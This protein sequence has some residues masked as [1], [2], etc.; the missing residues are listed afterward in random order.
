MTFII[1]ILLVDKRPF[2]TVLRDLNEL[3]KITYQKI[4]KILIW[5]SS[6]RTKGIQKSVL[7]GLGD[8][9]EEFK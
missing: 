3:D 2:I 9:I 7:A 6:V 5:G 8:E 1:A 4:I